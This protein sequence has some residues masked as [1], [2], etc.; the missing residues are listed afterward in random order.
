MKP[1]NDR[2]R[3]IRS[4]EI[5]IAK[6]NSESVRGKDDIAFQHQLNSNLALLAQE[7][8]LEVERINN[9]LREKIAEIHNSK[10]RMAVT[11]HDLKVPITISLL[12]LELCEME[13]DSHEK[14]D[15]ITAVRRELEMLLDTIANMLAMEQEQSTNRSSIFQKLDLHEIVDGVIGRMEVIIKDK[16]DLKIV[17]KLPSRAPVIK[18]DRHK[19][20]RVFSNLISNSIKYTDAGF[21]T[22]EGKSQHKR[23][24]ARLTVTDTGQGIQ[25][26]RLATL[27]EFFTGDELRQDSSGVGLAF[28]KQVVNAHGGKVWIASEVMRGT[29]VTMEFPLK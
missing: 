7:R 26:E 21:I 19:M 1:G 2:T 5:K 29:A 14:A 10:E 11:I 13:A 9:L 3:K 8:A 28:V 24:V 17:N 20:I 6:L 27:F 15:Y 16:P 18:G 4:L 22:I 12:N 23:G 25:P